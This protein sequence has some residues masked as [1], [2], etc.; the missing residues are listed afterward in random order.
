MLAEIGT[1]VSPIRTTNVERGAARS[2]LFA[3]VFESWDVRCSS[4][5]FCVTPSLDS[6]NS[7]THA[8]I[9][10]LRFEILIALVTSTV[11]F[12][13]YARLH[14]FERRPSYVNCTCLHAC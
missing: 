11:L 5:T 9:P 14:R 6:K 3:F 4:R 13:N 7:C 10:I 2:K 12:N 1:L 8:C